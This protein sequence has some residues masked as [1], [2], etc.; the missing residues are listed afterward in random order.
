MQGWAVGVAQ[1]CRGRGGSGSAVA[2]LWL[3]TS[4][5]HEVKPWLME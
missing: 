2:C 3:H 1:Q 4:L 5:L